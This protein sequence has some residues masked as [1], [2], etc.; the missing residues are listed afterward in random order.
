MKF[1]GYILVHSILPLVH[2]ISNMQNGFPDGLVVKNLP[3][4]AGD[5]ALIPGSGKSPGGGNGNLPQYSCLGNPM[6]RE[7]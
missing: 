3:A 4:S 5:R 2:Q 1:G 6:Y 7:A